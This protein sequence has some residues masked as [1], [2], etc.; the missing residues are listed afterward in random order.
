MTPER[1]AEIRDALTSGN[2]NAGRLRLEAMAAEMLE[3]LDAERARSAQR[4][5]LAAKQ[6][7]ALADSAGAVRALF[8]ATERLRVVES[9]LRALID[10]AHC[11]LRVATF[12]YTD[13]GTSA[14][15]A[16]CEAITHANKV[17]GQKGST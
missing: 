2:E 17:L 4:A 16:L 5:A 8:L 9:S 1:E 3:A 15:V 6:E 12:E 11:G 10:V 7:A 14:Y 13:Q